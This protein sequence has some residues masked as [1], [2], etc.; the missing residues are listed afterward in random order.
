MLRI[1]LG[2]R[3]KH[4]GAADPVDGFGLELDGVPLLRPASEEPLTQ[5][6]EQVFSATAAL[7]RGQRVVQV[8]LPESAQTLL[9]VRT[10]EEL[11]L[12]ILRLARPAGEVRR[13]VTVDVE[14]W[15]RAAVR[16][17]RDWLTDLRSAPVPGPLRRRARELLA[18]AEREIRAPAGAGT[19]RSI[20]IEPRGFPGFRLEALDPGGLLDGARG[21][22]PVPIGPLALPGTLGLRAGDAVRCELRG[23]VGLLALEL[24]RQ[25]EEAVRALEAGDARIRIVPAGVPPAWEVDLARATVTSPGWSLSWAGE[26]LVRALAAP[27]LDLAGLLT[28]LEPELVH[29]P[30][31]VDLTA[32]GRQVHAALR[33]LLAEPG[34][35]STTARPRR[36]RPAPPLQRGARVRRLGFVRRLR[37]A[38]LGGEGA[39]R[40]LALPRGFVVA[41]GTNASFV[42][43]DGTLGRRWAAPRGIAVGEGGEALLAEER[44]WLRAELATSRVRWF[45][46]HDGATLEGEL[47]DTPGELVVTTEGEGV[48]AVSRLTGRELW[49]FLPQ[50]SQRL[51]L[52]FQAGRVLVA[53]ELGIL[54]GLDAAE[55]T[56]RFRLASA[57]PFLGPPVPWGRSL[58]AAQGSADRG[59][60]LA[61]DARSG[62]VRWVHD[63]TLVPLGPPLPRGTSV[64]ALGIRDGSAVL[65]CLGARGA[66]RWER[67]LPPGPGPWTLTGDGAASLVTAGDGSAARIDARG[68]LEWRLGGQSS[69]SAASSVLVRGVLLVPGETVRAVDAHSGRVVAELA[70]AEGVHALGA[71]EALDVAVLDAA[72]DLSLWRLGAS[73]GLVM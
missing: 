2:Q 20:R 36:S 39:A 41:A 19:A 32:R 51:H 30:H 52:G 24:L 46:E 67:R 9:L 17:G 14:A 70:D 58:V 4:E 54:H 28:A 8:T 69:R 35:E 59:A 65:V 73:L 27:A 62:A 13:P 3:W 15:Q 12:Q 25:A 50:R 61:A 44:R 57:L 29:N 21:K 38:G 55:G 16:I 47:L 31:L 40:I 71:T 11:V 37:A 6:M 72:G 34:P 56:V 49:R 53:S 63:L 66:P 7:A 22:V 42:A 26:Q 45:R 68:H 10:G 64:R 1:R 48:R 33:A 18:R 43:S 23:P 5:V 60:I